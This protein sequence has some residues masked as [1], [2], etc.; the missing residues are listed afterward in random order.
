M[1]LIQLSISFT[2]SF[3]FCI[4]QSRSIGRNQSPKLWGLGLFLSLW[5][6]QKRLLHAKQ[7]VS[8]VLCSIIL[9]SPLFCFP[10]S[11]KSR[12]FSKYLFVV[13][14]KNWI[15]N[16]EV[17]N[18]K[19]SHWVFC[20]QTECI[21]MKCLKVWLRYN[22]SKEKSLSHQFTSHLYWPIHQ[23]PTTPL[24]YY[25]IILIHL[26][27]LPTHGYRL[28]TH[29]SLRACLRSLVGRWFSIENCIEK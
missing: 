8:L 21:E 10:N 5:K 25:T 18:I 16:F 3:L 6:L 24:H 26:S 1:S 17:L 22:F 23:K 28:T 7:T 27:R 29:L 2:L 19:S 14:V 13:F 9:S 15:V 20:R 4:A 12:P 11:I